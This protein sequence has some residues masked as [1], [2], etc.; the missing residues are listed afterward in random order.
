MF[1]ET[2]ALNE[3]RAELPAWVVWGTIVCHALIAF[4]AAALTIWIGTWIAER[5]LRRFDGES[6]TERA[7]LAYPARST[8]LLLL[9]AAPLI[10]VGIP[11]LMEMRSG[12]YLS[13]CPVSYGW[14]ALISLFIVTVVLS[15]SRR[16]LQGRVLGQ[17]ITVGDWL[18]SQ[19]T[20]VLLFLPYV[21]IVVL[22]LATLGDRLDARAG[23]WIGLGLLLFLFVLAGGNLLV[24][25]WLGVVS[26][27]S[28]RL[29]NIVNRCSERIGVW[30]RRCYEVKWYAVNALAFPVCRSIA[31]T[32]RAMRELDDAEIE[33][34]CA[35]EFGHLT[36]S[37]RVIFARL[38]ALIGLFALGV[39]RPFV[40]MFAGEAAWETWLATIPAVLFLVLFARVIARR[41]ERRADAIASPDDESATR[42][43]AALEK[44]Y[45]ANLAPAVMASRVRVHPHLYDR[46][47]AAGCEPNYPR[48]S[49]P[50]RFRAAIATTLALGF[51]FFATLVFLAVPRLLPQ[52]PSDKAFYASIA[53][54]GGN[55]RCYGKWAYEDHRRNDLDGAILK[56][57]LA[58]I[59][60]RRDWQ[61]PGNLTTAFA[62]SA[63]CGE[64]RIALDEAKSRFARDLRL[65]RP[66]RTGE[67][68]YFKSLERYLASR[69][70]PAEEDSTIRIRLFP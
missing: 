58:A 53:M 69:C 21:L 42:F 56:W 45:R 10:I 62:G 41:M 68:E 70:R 65:T 4:L 33:A 24:G 29:Q 66:E 13:V 52:G 61:S 28:T 37:K 8:S 32:D 19:T 67:D 22:M 60:D 14:I 34:I 55:A 40:S 54:D 18:Q 16:R 7:R 30:P 47:I 38:L 59:A 11:L 15:N 27:A 51:A 57:R 9:I 17:R 39:S 5:P 20:F 3:L 26:P 48:P 6:W 63:R 44:V 35:H 1:D 2:A 23:M 31:L 64:A 12:L 50:S 46:L 25:R 43:A 49:P 36:E